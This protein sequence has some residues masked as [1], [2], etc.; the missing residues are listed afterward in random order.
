MNFCHIYRDS[1]STSHIADSSK[2]KLEVNLLSSA[3][4]IRRELDLGDRIVL[5]KISNTG[6]RPFDVKVY[7]GNPP[8]E[9][10]TPWTGSRGVDASVLAAAIPAM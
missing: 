7:L 1:A 8:N 6:G 9:K 5:T 4:C 2:V 3:S 10:P